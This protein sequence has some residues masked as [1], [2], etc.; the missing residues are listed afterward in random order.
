MDLWVELE[1]TWK[2]C[3][4]SQC[5]QS[6]HQLCRLGVPLQRG[7]SGLYDNI[8][9]FLYILTCKDK[10]LFYP[11]ASCRRLWT[12]WGRAWGLKHSRSTWTSQCAMTIGCLMR[13]CGHCDTQDLYFGTT[14]G[15]TQVW[16]SMLPPEQRL[17]LYRCSTFSQM[18]QLTYRIR[19]Q[20][21]SG[22]PHFKKVRTKRPTVLSIINFKKKSYYILVHLN[23]VLYFSPGYPHPQPRVWE[24]L[25]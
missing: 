25:H 21:L 1:W 22:M 7:Q 12:G 9:A 15:H 19:F 13:C 18:E 14:P 16:S 3:S 24:V 2:I 5:E 6:C 11:I 10:N 17:V 8:R 4:S 20:L 23:F